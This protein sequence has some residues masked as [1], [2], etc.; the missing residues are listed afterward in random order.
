V[1]TELENVM[2]NAICHTTGAKVKNARFVDR[3][4]DQIDWE[5]VSVVIDFLTKF[6]RAERLPDRDQK[7][8]LL[9]IVILDSFRLLI[10]GRVPPN[11]TLVSPHLNSNMAESFAMVMVFSGTN[12]LVLII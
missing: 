4:G 7:C 1:K 5:K 11:S 9:Q 12:H 6:D 2:E 3:N 8:I 10:R